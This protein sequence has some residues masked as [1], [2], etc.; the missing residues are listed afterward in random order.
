MPESTLSKMKAGARLEPKDSRE[1]AKELAQVL[2][3]VS[4]R[5]KGILLVHDSL[6]NTI[7]LFFQMFNWQVGYE[8]PFE[9]GDWGPE[10][11]VFDVVATKG[12][13]QK[14]VEVKDTVGPRDLGQ[15]W[16][17]INALQLS[18]EHGQVYLGTDMLNYGGLLSGRIGAMVKKLME[19]ERMGVI[20]ADKYV[21]INCHNYAQLA[22]EEMP[23]IWASEE[24]V[25]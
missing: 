24:K 8:V 1:L 16:G 4:Q 3:V 19:H 7:G 12:R 2:Q 15:V 11:M 21:Q 22:L 10:R 23:E 25:G 20:L 5:R 6:Q 9:R 13:M 18:S 14:I 17:Y